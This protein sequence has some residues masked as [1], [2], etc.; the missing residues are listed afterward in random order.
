MSRLSPALTFETAS[1]D[2]AGEARFQLLAEIDRLGS[3]SAAAKAT[4]FS[5]KGAWD[6]VN[7]MNNLFPRPLIV[8]HAGGSSGGGTEVTEEGRRA[9]AAHRQLTAALGD[10]MA[11]LET[12]ISEAPGLSFPSENMFWS[13]FMRTSARNSYHGVIEAVSHGAVNAEI[14]LRIA[15][16]VTIAVIVTEPSVANLG[17][18]PGR[19]AYALIKAS[20]PILLE[21]G[22]NVLSSARN[23]ISGTVVSVEPGAV[24]AEVVLDIGGGKTLCAIITAKSAEA[25]AILPGKRMTALIKA[26]QIILAL[27]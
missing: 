18:E 25:M 19:E 4:G 1:G 27:G 24:N 23:R 20:T 13:P 5:Y 21:D 14:L 12:V 16:D 9:L 2:R 22:N 26:S 3:I 6:A 10:V 17:L 7:A 15:P 8:K 11:R